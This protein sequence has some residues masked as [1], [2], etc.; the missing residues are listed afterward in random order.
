MVHL[1]LHEVFLFGKSLRDIVKKL[2]LVADLGM[3][4]KDGNIVDPSIK[5][6]SSTLTYFTC[7]TAKQFLYR[8]KSSCSQGCR[9]D[10]S[11]LGC[12]SGSVALP[13]VIITTD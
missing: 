7:E 10:L 9:Q 8:S 12:L 11:L 13:S 2:Q 1:N 6:S 3:E 5:W 4:Q